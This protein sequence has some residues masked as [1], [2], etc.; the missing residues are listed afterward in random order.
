MEPA[1]GGSVGGDFTV[2]KHLAR[3][4]P[5]AGAFAMA[6]LV[7]IVAGPAR[8][9]FALRAMADST[10]DCHHE[11]SYTQTGPLFRAR[12]TG[13]NGGM[14]PLQNAPNGAPALPGPSVATLE[15]IN[16]NGNENFAGNESEA[17]ASGFT[18][19]GGFLLV[20]PIVNDA[21]HKEIF[22]VVGNSE[23]C[24]H[25]LSTHI[26]GRA[27]TS[28]NLT[29][30]ARLGDVSIGIVLSAMQGIY[31]VD[32]NGS[33]QSGDVSSSMNA[34]FIRGVRGVVGAGLAL[35]Q[36]TGGTVHT[37]PY[38]APQVQL[39]GSMVSN[40]PMSVS[41]ETAGVMDKATGDY[42]AQCSVIWAQAP[43]GGKSDCIAFARLN[44]LNL[45][46]SFCDVGFEKE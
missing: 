2:K 21:V 33:S 5:T 9:G 18:R 37:T 29:L 3:N 16:Y 4:L 46:D 39:G 28:V 38:A 27:S 13:P 45:K 40:Q 32:C 7:V 26:F 31:K 43:R 15:E 34:I 36:D 30:P 14:V 23:D 25:D 35:D 10:G 22:L 20:T 1:T 6:V 42:T 17:S 19:N 8:R 24:C 44:K 12:E 11:Y 41:M